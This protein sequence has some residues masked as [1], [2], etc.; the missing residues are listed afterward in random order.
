M[1]LEVGE[2]RVVLE[3]RA[4]RRGIADLHLALLAQDLD[5]ERRQRGRRVEQ[6]L[7]LVPELLLRG[8]DAAIR[9][10]QLVDRGQQL[11]LVIVI[12]ALE[13]LVAAELELGVDELLDVLTI[14]HRLGEQILDA[15]IHLLEHLVEVAHELVDHVVTG[16]GVG[17]RHRELGAGRDE[18]AD[19][20]PHERLLGEVELAIDVPERRQ[21]ED[22]R[23]HLL[24]GDLWIGAEGEHRPRQ[25]APW[26][27]VGARARVDVAYRL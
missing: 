15:A 1:L 25:L 16:L 12:E 5:V 6:G 24:L 26:V 27:A 8:V 4:D 20:D 13:D 19:V 11:L 14:G 21:V 3:P 7:E 10:D 9:V 18:L 23:V 2:E 22:D 17:I